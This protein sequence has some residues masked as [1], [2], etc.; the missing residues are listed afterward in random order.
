[1]STITIT[2]CDICHTDTNVKP[3]NNIP[4]TFYTEQTEGRSVEPYLSMVK[5]DICLRCLD[6]IIKNQP[7]TGTGAQGNNEYNFVEGVK[8]E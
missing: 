2:K 1:M 3:I 8:F 4:V 6:M 7:L 5:M